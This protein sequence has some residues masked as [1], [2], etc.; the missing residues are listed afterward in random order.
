MRLMKF[1]SASMST[2]EL[3]FAS[4]SR[5][6]I[7]GFAAMLLMPRDDLISYALGVGAIIFLLTMH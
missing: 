6:G 4:S 2:P 7:F 3:D 1:P 5:L